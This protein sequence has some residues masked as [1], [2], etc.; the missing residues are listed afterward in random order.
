MI[1]SPCKVVHRSTN[2]AIETPAIAG[3]ADF[4]ATPP[5]NAFGGG[6][7][8]ARRPP[9]FG[10]YLVNGRASC[11][12]HSS[13]TADLAAAKA[14]SVPAHGLHLVR[15]PFMRMSS[16]LSALLQ[17][18]RSIDVPALSSTL[19]KLELLL[20]PARTEGCFD[21]A[22][23]LG[24][25]CE[26]VMSDPGAAIQIFRLSGSE[27][28]VPDERP[29]SVANCI[30]SF[31]TRV[32]MDVVSSPPFPRDANYAMAESLWQHSAAI[33]QQARQIAQTIPGVNP[34]EA[35][36]AGLLH[37]IGMLPAA[38]GWTEDSRGLPDSASMGALLA[39]EW[40]LPQFIIDAVESQG[41]AEF[42]PPS[43]GPSQSINHQRTDWSQILLA[44]HR[45]EAA[46][47]CTR[48]PS[49]MRDPRCSWTRARPMTGR[50]KGSPSKA[51]TPAAQSFMSG[52]SGLHLC[53][54]LE[55]PGAASVGLAQPAMN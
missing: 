7:S 48:R 26:V 52:Y 6:S 24:A 3:H 17:S 42:R 14:S 31:E 50:G 16:S 30:G 11:V 43:A 20:R 12:A 15:S 21:N 27:H 23:D 29:T 2:I 44:A 46:S 35:C 5:G 28:D 25:V 36:L 8:P 39:R 47:C 22:V 1:D 54:T 41:S 10:M 53:A 55:Q 9:P 51:L 13:V 34:D 38:L 19:L 40:S 32:W 45:I 37:D 18:C 33:A 4:H 49:M